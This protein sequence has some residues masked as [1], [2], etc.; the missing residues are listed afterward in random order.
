MSAH[1]LDLLYPPAC[2]LCHARLVPAHRS[3]SAPH[4]RLTAP[5]QGQSG[6]NRANEKTLVTPATKE[7]R[8][9]IRSSPLFCADC[10]KLMPR[11]H[12]PVCVRCGITIPGAFDAHALCRICRQHPLAFD[13]ARSPWQYE[14][15]VQ[16]AIRQFKYRQRWRI[17]RKLAD[18]MATVA[19]A[20]LPLQDIAVILPVPL[21][22]LKRWL[23]GCNP[24]ESLARDVARSL[25]KPCST[26]IISR[27]RW[28][29]TQTRLGWSR[30]FRNVRQAFAVRSRAIQ[31]S[32]VL[33]V[34]DV[35]TSGATA[36]ACARAL[37]DAGAR[38]VFVLTA[39]R[40][41]L[42]RSE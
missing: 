24:A 4:D 28:T 20:H 6:H 34:D 42:G 13:L 25:G 21:H 40:T 22:R 3:Q 15:S 27:T 35:L 36:D 1:L 7:R 17:G 14:G 41:P 10:L 31:G 30:R 37:K 16:V 5:Q 26:R 18:D 19:R 9:S 8:V 38:W 33:L 29:T 12:A 23:K 11:M 32:D 39:A 2:L